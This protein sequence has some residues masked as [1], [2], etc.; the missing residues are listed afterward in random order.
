MSDL[1]KR[2]KKVTKRN[3]FWMFA[4]FDLNISPNH[5]ISIMYGS[6]QAGFICAGGLCRFEPEFEG[7][8][9]KF[10]SRL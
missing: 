5:D 8:E 4:Q 10:F 1:Q 6:R 2:L 9:V 7:V 3:N